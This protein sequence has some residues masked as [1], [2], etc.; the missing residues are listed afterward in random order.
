MKKIKHIRF[1]I[2][3]QFSGRSSGCHSAVDIMLTEIKEVFPNAVFDLYTLGFPDF[4]KFFPK[5]TRYLKKI[6]M[7]PWFG[8]INFIGFPV[9]FNLPRCDVI[10]FRGGG[11]F[12]RKIYSPIYSYLLNFF[13]IFPYAKLLGKPIVSYSA[14]IGPFISPV[15][16]WMAKKVISKI[17]FLVVRESGSKRALETIGIKAHKVLADPVYNLKYTHDR[18]ILCQKL[19]LSEKDTY[20]GLNVTSLINSIVSNK[21]ENV[22][23]IDMFVEKITIMI[24]ELYS[25]HSIKT[26]LFPT[27]TEYE[28]FYTIKNNTN[29]PVSYIDRQTI[30][31]YQM[32][33]IMSVCK[34]FI[35]M[36]MHSLILAQSQ[37][38]PTIGLVYDYKIKYIM[39]DSNMNNYVFEVKDIIENAN[40]L[41][42]KIVAIVSNYE[43]EK[44][45]FKKNII[46]M[47]EKAKQMPFLLKEFLNEYYNRKS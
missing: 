40:I 7:N 34:C 13:I 32:A 9:L 45:F 6:S 46:P 14:G 18:K 23:T 43:K 37:Y 5:H 35:G 36:R 4:E 11:L 12:D 16:K 47:Q 38:V 29:A 42:D 17:A 27:D 33:S 3:D 21:N 15:S 28:I 19:K 31:P 44:A 24:N 22:V 30:D 25:K 41:F 20:I 8:S 1:A 39:N 10:L 2:L 26:I